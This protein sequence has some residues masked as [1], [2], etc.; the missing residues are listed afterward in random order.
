MLTN[1]L[2]LQCPLCQHNSHS[3][4]DLLFTHIVKSIIYVTT[5]AHMLKQYH[6]GYLITTIIMTVTKHY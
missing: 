3:T 4:H 6:L 1:S 2:L 5:L